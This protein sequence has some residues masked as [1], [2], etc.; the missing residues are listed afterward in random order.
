VA[1]TKWRLQQLGGSAERLRKLS[2]RRRWITWPPSRDV[3]VGLMTAMKDL[4]D[5]L[6]A[7]PFEDPSRR[8]DRAHAE[9]V[10]QAIGDFLSSLD[11]GFFKWLK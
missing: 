2:K 4:R 9:Q 1:E 3:S 7:D 8:I 5:E 6:T 11:E 10:E